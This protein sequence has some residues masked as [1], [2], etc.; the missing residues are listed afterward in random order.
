MIYE[1]GPKPAE[2][3]KGVHLING[4]FA[5]CWLSP[6][7]KASVQICLVL[8]L[9]R[10]SSWTD[11]F[12]KGY[13]AS[14]RHHLHPSSRARCPKQSPGAAETLCT[15]T[16]IFSPCKASLWEYDI[17]SSL[18]WYCTDLL[19]QGRYRFAKKP[20]QCY[21]YQAWMGIRDSLVYMM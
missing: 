13:S 3:C 7:S 6:L 5:L 18:F 14:R 16:W 2:Q 10:T 17:M 12:R 1:R 9:I 21:L 4:W 19:R 15:H 20:K 8:C 11:T